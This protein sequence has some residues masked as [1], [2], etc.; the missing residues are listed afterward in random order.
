MTETVMES[1][2]VSYHVC[3]AAFHPSKLPDT[4]RSDSHAAHQRHPKH[5]PIDR[6]AK[7]HCAIGTDESRQGIQRENRAPA[8]RYDPGRIDDGRREHPELH[9]ERDRVLDIAET[10]I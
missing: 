10:H 1:E 5:A 6:V 4:Q 2:S 7:G 9:Q 3:K 8:I